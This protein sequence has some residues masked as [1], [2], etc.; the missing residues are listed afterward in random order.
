MPIAALQ[1]FQ[2]IGIGWIWSVYN[3]LV[4]SIALLILVDA[5]RSS[6]YEW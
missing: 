5:P 1:D 6:V 4:I 3:L 2:G